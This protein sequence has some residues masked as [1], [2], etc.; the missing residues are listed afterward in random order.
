MD[1]STM[2]EEEIQVRLDAIAVERSVLHD[3]AHALADEQT[4]RA[5]VKRAREVA[6]ELGP[7][8]VA[9]LLRLAAPPAQS[10][11]PEPIA[12]SVAIV[13]PG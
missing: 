5:Q 2:T 7:A 6:A 3:E 12:A 11:E 1:I 8:G 4:L 9:E 13:E 10:I